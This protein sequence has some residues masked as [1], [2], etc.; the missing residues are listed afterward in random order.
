[1]THKFLRTLIGLLLGLL[2]CDALV[3]ILGAAPEVAVTSAGRYRI[4]TDPLLI[5]EPIPNVT[6][7]DLADGYALGYSDKSNALGFRGPLYAQE[8]P[9]N[10]RYR[11]IVLGDSIA[12]GYGVPEYA[13]TFPA[14]LE[15]KLSGSGFRTEVM[16][17]GV[18]GY[19]TTQEVETLRTKGLVYHPDLV[20]VAYC[21]NDTERGSMVGNELYRRAQAK[22]GVVERVW[23]HPVF[24]H[25]ALYR[26]LRYRVRP[27]LDPQPS[28]APVRTQ[29]IADDFAALVA[30]R[31]A[32][33]FQVPL[34]IFPILDHLDESYPW[35]CDHQGVVQ[36]A[37]QTGF[38]VLDLLDTMRECARVAAPSR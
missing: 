10:R 30:L 13:Q 32:N 11:I 7:R 37:R 17:F 14:V 20:I 31:D 25:S 24:I 36:L 3:R 27:Q 38:G 28:A 4:S 35:T 18:A 12:D 5:Y 23:S 22:P 16:D 29:M 21:L 6:G 34:V 8:Q 2:L 19:Q 33:G 1:M 26:F 9:E 15:R